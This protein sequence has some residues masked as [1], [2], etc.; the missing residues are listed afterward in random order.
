MRVV[1]AHLLAGLLVLC[2]GHAS[3]ARPNIVLIMA[4]DMGYSDIGCYGG[5]IET[6]HL[7]RL[8][9]E[10][11]RFTQFYNNAKC[12]PTRASL[13]TG[14]Y[15]QQAG[16]FNDPAPM[17][18]CVTLAEV[19]REAGYRTLMTGKWHAAEL[20]VER[21]FD[22]YYGLCDGCCNYFNPGEQRPG[23]A[24]PAEKNY[25]RKW[26]IEGQ[27]QQPFT[28]DD[29]NFNTTDAF[30]DHALQY[31][32]EFAK[33]DKPFF[34]YVAYTAPH[35]PLHAPEE[36]IQKYVG[37]YLR[38]WDVLRQER[39][40]RM[41]Q[42]GLL[43]P[44]WTLSPRE[45]GIPA[46]DRV[47]HAEAWDQNGFAA[48]L[49][50]DAITNPAQWDRAMATYAAMVDRMDRNIGRIVA[51]L[52]SQ[53]ER[54]NTLIL[55]LSDNGA[56]AEMRHEG[57]PA[58]G[59]LDGYHTVDPPWANLQNT[60]FRSYKSHNFEGGIATPL[61]AHW[62]GRIAPGG[63]TPQPGHIIDLMATVLDLAGAK[64]PSTYQGRNILPHAGKSLV[65]IFEG[66]DRAPHDHL[67]WS[68]SN[69]RAVRAG[70][71]KAVAHGKDAWALFD[72]DAD[73]T[74]Q[75]DLAA[76]HPERLKAMTAAWEAWRTT[77]NAGKESAP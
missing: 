72:L 2:T 14:L 48:K 65:P 47:Q 74:E 77:W 32:D 73:R 53:G 67:F 42:M 71:W 59:G 22:R 39:F 38:G 37:R 40:E 7:D 3:A 55:F 60:P 26:A 68:F 4:D 43:D 49:K 61:I 41:Q 36:D 31:L 15:S 35:Y 34:L 29:R 54:D 12:A 52:E 27:V 33:E 11:L 69:A 56:C 9:R 5:E 28:P 45:A 8:A 46:W 58:I 64:Y 50:L 13:L 18:H 6:P 16:V 19:L 30:T 75:N 44:R 10:G 24:A 25:P 62:P 63:L 70:Q 1:L 57:S 51:K 76:E 17:Q 20:P 21:G 23:E 66:K